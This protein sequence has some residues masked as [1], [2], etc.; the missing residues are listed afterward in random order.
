MNHLLG[1][2]RTYRRWRGVCCNVET[3]K[4]LAEWKTE[5]RGDSGIRLKCIIGDNFAFARI[6]LV[7]VLSVSKTHSLRPY[8]LT[9]V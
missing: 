8:D 9:A 3:K 4:Q 1:A 7:M 6:I 5:G 2:S